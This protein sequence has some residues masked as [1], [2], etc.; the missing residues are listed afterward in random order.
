MSL[1]VAD[2]PLLVVVL[3]AGDGPFLLF[4]MLPLLVGGVLPLLVGG[5]LPLLVDGV[6][7]LLVGGVLLGVVVGVLLLGVVGVLPLLVAQALLF[8]AIEP[9]FADLFHLLFD[10]L[11]LDAYILL[12]VASDSVFLPA[13]ALQLFFDVLRHVCLAVLRLAV[14]ALLLVADFHLVVVVVVVVLLLLL[15]LLLLLA[16]S[17]VFDRFVVVG[18]C[19][20]VCD[21][22]RHLDPKELLSADSPGDAVRRFHLAP[23][24][25]SL[26]CQSMVLIAAGYL[27]PKF[28]VLDPQGRSFLPRL[29]GSPSER[30]VPEESKFFVSRILRLDVHFLQF[31]VA[32][33]F[34]LLGKWLA[35]RWVR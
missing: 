32:L 14:D 5:V 26:S 24:R 2:F 16:Y 21:G 13:D 29:A 19:H 28:G 30:L 20:L 27:V 11:L 22:Q 8:P 18:T 17:K 3:L 1:L 25:F 31:C 12:A 10:I 35:E 9:L 4:G 15:L 6:L 33:H 7:P 23:I 34:L